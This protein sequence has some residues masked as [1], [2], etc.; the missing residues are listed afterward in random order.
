MAAKFT[1]DV[2]GHCDGVLSPLRA[3]LVTGTPVVIE[4]CAR[5]RPSRMEGSFSVAGRLAMDAARKRDAWHLLPSQSTICEPESA[6]QR[7][8]AAGDVSLSRT[9]AEGRSSSRCAAKGSESREN[10]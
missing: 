5:R 7:S 2:G 1:L 10:E 9:C 3:S 8:L 4:C 6:G